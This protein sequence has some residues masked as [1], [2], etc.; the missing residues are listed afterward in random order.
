MLNRLKRK[1][2]VIIVYFISITILFS[3]VLSVKATDYGGITSG[4]TKSGNIVTEGQ[5]DSFTF[6]GKKDQGIHVEMSAHNS[7][8]GTAIYLYSPDGSLEKEVVGGSSSNIVRIEDHHL[9]QTGTYTIVAGASRA[10]YTTRT[11]EYGLSL[12]LVGGSSTSVQDPDGG[13]ITSGQ[14]HKCN[15]KPTGDTDIYTFYGKKDQGIHIEMSADNNS[16]G[17]AIYLY[18]PNGSLEKKVVGGSSHTSVRIEDYHL[19][20]TGT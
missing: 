9:L 13:A 10:A 2:K 19:L 1:G 18:S 3:L 7:D 8:L 11:G 17:S 16:L 15:I 20:Q 4:E 12:V 14:T 6:Y 5:L